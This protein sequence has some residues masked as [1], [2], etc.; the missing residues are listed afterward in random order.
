MI[1]R[2]AARFGTKIGLDEPFMAEV[3]K[4]VI[5][6]YGEA[7]P[8]LV[9][10]EE[11]ILNQLTREEK[12]FQKTVEGGIAQLENLMAATEKAGGKVLDAKETFELYATHGLPLELTRDIALEHGLKVDEAGFQEAME[13]H[14]IASGG[15]QAMGDLGGE[16][17]EAFQEILI[18]FRRKENW[19]R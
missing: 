4:I 8:E 5:K 14:R 9:K 15:G 7:Y 13:A 18:N 19:K 16:D 1:V 11:I 3:A 10:N 12:R 17:A 6:N 2:R